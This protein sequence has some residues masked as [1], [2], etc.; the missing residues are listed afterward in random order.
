MVT[1][2]S[3]WAVPMAEMSYP[4]FLVILFTLLATPSSPCLALDE[5]RKVLFFFPEFIFLEAQFSELLE[6]YSKMANMGS[7]KGMIKRRGGNDKS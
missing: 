3:I 5:D 7:N 4:L 2:S 1:V 6:V